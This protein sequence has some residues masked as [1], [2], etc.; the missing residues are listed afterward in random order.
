VALS[1]AASICDLKISDNGT[2]APAGGSDDT[3]F[4]KDRPPPSGLAG[5]RDRVRRLG[6]TVTAGPDAAGGFTV[7]ISIP[8]YAVE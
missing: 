2:A 4:R 6:G 5:I 8:R 7:H 1:C 3:E